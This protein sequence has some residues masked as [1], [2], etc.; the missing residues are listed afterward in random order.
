[1][2]GGLKS[3]VEGRVNDPGTGLTAEL[4]AVFS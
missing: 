4:E 2:D 1:V 3:F